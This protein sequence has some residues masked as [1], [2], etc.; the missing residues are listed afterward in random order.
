MELTG[1]VDMLDTF[2]KS[3]RAM[4]LESGDA[5][6]WVRSLCP[7][8]GKRTYRIQVMLTDAGWDETRVNGVVGARVIDASNTGTP[9]RDGDSYDTEW[10]ANE[11][12]LVLTDAGREKFGV[13]PHRDTCRHPYE[14]RWTGHIP[15]RV[16]GGTWVPG[17][18]FAECDRCG[19]RWF[20]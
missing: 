6:V 18:D 5:V 12:V 3:R 16:M 10:F 8:T 14:K 15:G 13:A 20:R 1:S 19:K 4:D 17:S 7:E 2:A 9:S 11:Y